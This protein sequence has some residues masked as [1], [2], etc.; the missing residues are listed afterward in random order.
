MVG[1]SKHRTSRTLADIRGLI[2]QIDGELREAE[3]LRNYAHER[4]RRRE[5]FPSGDSHQHPPTT[6]G[7]LPS[8]Q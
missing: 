3:R 5:V 7:N 4:S 1:M 6:A 2:E 8:T